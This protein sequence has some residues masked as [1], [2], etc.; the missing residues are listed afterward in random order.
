MIKNRIASAAALFTFGVAALGGAV[1][2]IAAPAHA[3][4]DTTAT[5]SS[6]TSGD[7][8]APEENMTGTAVSALA[9]AEAVPDELADATRGPDVAGVP[10]PGSA[11]TMEHKLFPREAAPHS[12]HDGQGHKGSNNEPKAHDPARHM[13]LPSKA[14]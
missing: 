8:A 2:A 11:A 12:E 13:G 6:Q 5:S 7:K 14:S 4:A 3:D 1:V 9:D 10:A